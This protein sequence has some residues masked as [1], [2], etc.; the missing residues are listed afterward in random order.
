MVRAK[1]GRTRI[2][3][4]LL[5]LLKEQPLGSINIVSLCKAANVSRATFYA[6]YSNVDDVYRELVR[7]LISVTSAM[8]S[9]LR[10]EECNTKAPLCV[11]LREGGRYAS[12]ANEDRFMSTFT[13][14]SLAELG[15]RVTAM[16]D[17]VSSDR[18]VAYALYCF[19][20]MGCLGA[21]RTIPSS[22]EWDKIR[23]SIDAFVRGGLNS[24]RDSNR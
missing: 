3:D 11:L 13:S 1:P 21:A 8:R 17:E 6:H 14:I 19:Q 12:L 10:C 9:Q 4:A 16:Y 7:E 18:D 15:D 2:N 22:V 24:I 5:N 23:T 20:M